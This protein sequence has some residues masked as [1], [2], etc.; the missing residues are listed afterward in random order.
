MQQYLVHRPSRRA[1]LR[2]ERAAAGAGSARGGWEHWE[3]LLRA[4]Y[5]RAARQGPRQG[6]SDA[7][8]VSFN[9]FS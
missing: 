7:S 1:Q 5:V 2:V 3:P 4:G 9:S 6:Q 8:Q